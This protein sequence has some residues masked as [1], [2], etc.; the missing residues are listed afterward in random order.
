[1][2]VHQDIDSDS[3]SSRSRNR[4][5]SEPDHTINVRP[6]PQEHIYEV[7]PPPLSFPLRPVEDPFLRDGPS[8]Y[9]RPSPVR[10]RD[11]YRPEGIRVERNEM[12]RVRPQRPPEG[13]RSG[14]FRPGGMPAFGVGPG[15]GVFEARRSY[16]EG[17]RRPNIV[18]EA[19]KPRKE[20]RI[21]GSFVPVKQ[22]DDDGGYYNSREP[23]V[24]EAY[25][26]ME[27]AQNTTS[28]YYS[29]GLGEAAWRKKHRE[30]AGLD[31]SPDPGPDG[32][33]PRQNVR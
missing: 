14:P 15:V 23:G 6:R 4:S 27:N 20:P 33:E 7:Q 26:T 1:M 19:V 2:S 18:I 32:P 9:R 17:N 8:H 3:D 21:P 22:P 12:P 5:I 16:E 28:N 24:R 11:R 30:R 10:H 29:G 25:P 13:R 31:H